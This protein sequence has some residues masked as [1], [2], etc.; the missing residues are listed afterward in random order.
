MNEVLEILKDGR[1]SD[2]KRLAALTGRSEYAIA[3]A[4]KRLLHR[5]D[6]VIAK[7]G[8]QEKRNTV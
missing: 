7:P 4:L 8:V 1:F 5:G 3:S 2:K 6:L